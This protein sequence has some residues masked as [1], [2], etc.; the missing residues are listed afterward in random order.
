MLRPETKAKPYYSVVGNHDYWVLGKSTVSTTLD[1]CGN[2]FIQWNGQDTLASR[3]NEAKN[4]PYDLSVDPR[5]GRYLFGCNPVDIANTFFF[6]QLGNVGFIGYSPITPWNQQ[7]PHF[8]EA[9]EFFN[10]EESV[11]VIVLLGHWNIQNLDCQEG[12]GL[13][14]LAGTLANDYEPCGRVFGKE[15][16]FKFVSGHVHCN[17]KDTSL[18]HPT[19]RDLLL[20]SWFKRKQQQEQEKTAAEVG[21][22][23]ELKSQPTGTLVAGFGMH[24]HGCGQFGIPI[25]DS[26][27]GRYRV[28]YFPIVD[29]SNSDFGPDRYDKIVECVVRK[30]TWR[31]CTELAVLFADDPLPPRGSVRKIA[32]GGRV[33]QEAAAAKNP[34]QEAPATRSSRENAA[35]VGDADLVFQ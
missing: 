21:V 5:A 22:H 18:A 8:R 10:A 9:C 14:R 23:G 26:T 17:S 15:K 27:E 11:D 20:P 35:A 3:K 13:N 19:V 1:Q 24:A 31:E 2:A 7:E 6:N 12:M 28:W 25:V 30:G 34:R 33:S 16:R 29:L 4:H 32:S